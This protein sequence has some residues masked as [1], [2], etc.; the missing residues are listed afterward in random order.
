MPRD[1]RDMVGRGVRYPFDVST[2]SVQ[3][4]V[5][6]VDPTD[7]DRRDAMERRLRHLV[8]TAVGQRVLFRE[9]GTD[10]TESLFELVGPAVLGT[11]M[12]RVRQ[13][14][15]RWEPRVEITRSDYKV[16]AENS[17]VFFSMHWRLSRAGL[18][19][20]AVVPLGLKFKETL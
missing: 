1:Y 3:W 14:L 19:G 16:D 6:L 13:A 15:L 12:Y 8:R 10:L 11:A 2:G 4:S 18:S 9:Y 17:L 7:T 20:A 5:P